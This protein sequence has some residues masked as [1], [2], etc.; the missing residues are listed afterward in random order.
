MSGNCIISF[1][2]S[3]GNY[4][5]GISRLSESLRNNFDGKFLAFIGEES[6]GSPLHLENPYAFKVYAFKK[7]LEA[8]FTNIMYLDSSCFA[9]RNVQ[10]CFDD[11]ANNGFLFQDAG[12]YCGNWCNDFTLNYHSVTR[13]DAMQMKMIGNAGLLGL[14]FDMGLP[15][16]FFMQWELSMIAGCFK[17]EWTNSNKNESVDERCMGARHDMSN[18][19]LIIQK[20]GLFNLAK[21]G[22]ELLQYAGVYD[23]TSSDKIIFKAQGL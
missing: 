5:R 3:K 17:G 15:K 12:H 11:I 23:E 13:D 16:D 20:M 22:D 18:S 14:N 8:G 19:S 2:N 21:T 6:I 1:A 7:A 10:S 4:V 9:I